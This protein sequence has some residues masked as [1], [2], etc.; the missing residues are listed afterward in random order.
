MTVPPASYTSP[1]L[2]VTKLLSTVTGPEFE[3]F[4]LVP[5]FIPPIRSQAVTQVLGCP[6]MV[7]RPEFDA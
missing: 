1:G 7:H 2:Y 3:H 5:D 4:V 6:E